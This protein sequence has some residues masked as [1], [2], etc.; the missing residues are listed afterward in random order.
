MQNPGMDIGEYL[1]AESFRR[2]R[3]KR[4]AGIHGLAA[5]ADLSRVRTAWMT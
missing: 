4:P 2:G 5:A 3:R 1:A